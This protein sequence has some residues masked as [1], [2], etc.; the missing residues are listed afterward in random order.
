VFV[1]DI[2][3]FNVDTQE[4]HVSCTFESTLPKLYRCKL[5]TSMAEKFINT[6]PEECYVEMQS[7]TDRHERTLRKKEIC[8]RFN[9][10]KGE[11]ECV[12]EATCFEGLDGQLKDADCEDGMLAVMTECTS[13][14]KAAVRT[15]VGPFQSQH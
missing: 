6:T 2:R 14:P 3:G 9:S 8:H 12:I 7:I 13:K 11:C 1:V 5:S 15:S 10:L 4:F